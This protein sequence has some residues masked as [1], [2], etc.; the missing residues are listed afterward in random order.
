MVSLWKRDSYFPTK[1][2]LNFIQ[3]LLSSVIFEPGIPCLMARN[4]KLGV[5]WLGATLLG[6][7]DFILQG[8][9]AL[10]YPVD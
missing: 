10:F 2:K 1:P 4:P 7:H 9:R 8:M 5:P 3:S 6:I